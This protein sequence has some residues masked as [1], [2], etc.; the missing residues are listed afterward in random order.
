MP[1]GGG[2]GGVIRHGNI[3]THPV[4]TQNLKDVRCCDG[5]SVTLE[6]H[7]E[8][9]PSPAVVWERDGKVVGTSS[10]FEISYV[11]DRATLHIRR[12]F[13]E[14]EGEYICVATNNI[15]KAYSSAFLIVDGKES[16][17]WYMSTFSNSQ[18]HRFS[19][20]RKGKLRQSPIVQTGRNPVGQLNATH[21]SSHDSR[22][23]H[24]TNALVLP[25]DQH[26]APIKT[27]PPMCGAQILRRSP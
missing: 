2:V 4:F 8:S 7:V 18:S 20:R 13:P 25:I 1:R 26:R 14:D 24:L 3:E 17:I 19:A 10:D 9:L 23:E 6:C 5:D 22:P 12:V 11:D 15:G 27:T 16:V 21:N